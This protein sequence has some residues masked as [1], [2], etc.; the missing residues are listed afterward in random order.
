MHGYMY[1]DLNPHSISALADEHDWYCHRPYFVGS[2]E[3]YVRLVQ[4]Y[5]NAE[6]RGRNVL[7]YNKFNLPT[8]DKL[9]AL[10]LTQMREH[11]SNG[12]K[13]IESHRFVS[14]VC[15]RIKKKNK[16]KL[17]IN[18]ERNETFL[19]IGQSGG[20][21]FMNNNSLWNE[22]TGVWFMKNHHSYVNSNQLKTCLP[23]TF[24]IQ[25]AL[26]IIWIRLNLF[27]RWPG[28][29]WRALEF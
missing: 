29:W 11:L 22:R 7:Q 10:V 1:V 18:E 27:H 15:I 3:Y 21:F 25:S 23:H 28:N 9:I 19:C 5:R 16:K 4:I 8:L 24:F 20:R 17:N 14:S 26:R 2:R 13:L 6:F 12:H